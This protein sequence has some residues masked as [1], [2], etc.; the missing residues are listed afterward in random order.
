MK[1]DSNPLQVA[2]A[3]YDEP[4]DVNMIEATEGLHNKGPM[5]GTAEGFKQGVKMTE[6]TEGL[7]V[8]LQK[9]RIVDG[10]NMQV[11]MIELGE[12]VDMRADEESTRQSK[13]QVKVSYPKKD[14][15]LV[16]FIDPLLEEEV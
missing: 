13:D 15:N 5:V 2:H 7:K 6:A 1:I 11:N 9:I 4:I 8:R 16:E 12:D 14:E 10:P 3:H